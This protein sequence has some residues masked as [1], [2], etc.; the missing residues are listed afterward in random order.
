MMMIKSNV[1][2]ILKNQIFFVVYT[3]FIKS[4]LKNTLVY[5]IKNMELILLTLFNIFLVIIL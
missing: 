5:N 1:F 4:K 3:V 2:N